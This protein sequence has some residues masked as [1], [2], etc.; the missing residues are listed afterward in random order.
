MGYK[1]IKETK[2]A[3]Y[4]LQFESLRKN[5]HEVTKERKK[6]FIFLFFYYIMGVDYIHD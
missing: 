2:K 5:N 1:G 3:Q 6:N 4:C